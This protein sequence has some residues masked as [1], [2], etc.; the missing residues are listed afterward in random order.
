MPIF[1]VDYP[2]KEMLPEK[3]QIELD[4]ILAN[5]N[6]SFLEKVVLL[7]TMLQELEVGC[8]IEV[9]I[10]IE[11]VTLYSFLFNQE[12]GR[13]EIDFASTP[14]ILSECFSGKKSLYMTSDMVL[15]NINPADIVTAGDATRGASEK[16]GVF[17]AEGIFS[18]W[19]DLKSFFALMGV[20]INHP[21]YQIFQDENY[22]QL[23]E[24]GGWDE[25]VIVL[26]DAVPL[27]YVE[28]IDNIKRLHALGA[29]I[30][31]I[32]SFLQPS[33]EVVEPSSTFS[34]VDVG[35][36]NRLFPIPDFS[37]DRVVPRAPSL[38]QDGSQY[39]VQM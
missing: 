17:P 6:T 22:E 37:Q 27:F 36:K 32:E 16:Q 4:A 12:S 15:A 28:G 10:I 9:R 29:P 39:R 18:E 31:Q 25:K 21:Y 19:K 3:N 20:E 34:E 8:D 2:T 26:H 30:A 1:N 14:E 35:S 23:H 5:T 11:A 24:Q 38:L 33:N 7:G 13:V